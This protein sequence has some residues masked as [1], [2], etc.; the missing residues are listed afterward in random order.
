MASGLIASALEIDSEMKDLWS[1]EC[2]VGTA[3]QWEG[4]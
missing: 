1:Q 3:M 4:P 2:L